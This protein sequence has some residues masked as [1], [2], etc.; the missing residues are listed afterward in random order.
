MLGVN[1]EPLHGRQV[2]FFLTE[3]QMNLKCKLDSVTLV[4]LNIPGRRK[5]HLGQGS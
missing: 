3:P 1:Q 4:L 2:F 5:P